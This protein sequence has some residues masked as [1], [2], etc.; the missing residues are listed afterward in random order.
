M[1]LRVLCYLD[2]GW[3][4]S[5]P[6]ALN[7]FCLHNRLD[8]C[9]RNLPS[10]CG[11]GPYCD[12]GSGCTGHSAPEDVKQGGRGVFSPTSNHTT[13]FTV[14]LP[15][16]SGPHLTGCTS[17]SLRAFTHEAVQQSVA[18]AAVPTWTAGTA[19]PRNITVPTH[20][21]RLANTLVAS[22]HLLEQKPEV[23]KK[24]ARVFH[25]DQSG[26]ASCLPSR[27]NTIKLP[28]FVRALNSTRKSPKHASTSVQGYFSKAF[29]RQCWVSE[30]QHWA[31]QIFRDMRSD[32]N[33]M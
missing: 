2:T 10:R 5:G 6:S 11:T 19:V 3:S 33:V 4:C 7:R 18:A 15:A 13:V 26:R 31:G 14:Y 16:G 24:S 12:R 17:E 20:E 21:S 28:G 23:I 9:S 27:E 30:H 1:S 32:D 22:G 29:Y 8:S 25:D